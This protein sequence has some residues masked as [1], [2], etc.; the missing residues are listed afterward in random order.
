[1]FDFLKTRLCI[2]VLRTPQCF[3]FLC[4]FFS[5]DLEVK[6]L[7]CQHFIF[8]GN[9]E[10]YPALLL[11]LYCRSQRRTMLLFQNYSVLFLRKKKKKSPLLALF[12]SQDFYPKWP[13]DC[14][15]TQ[16]SSAPLVVRVTSLKRANVRDNNLREW[17]WCSPCN[18]HWEIS[19]SVLVLYI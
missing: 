12:V 2:F 4:L 8:Y 15:Y 17:A 16:Q 11:V 3:D 9:P 14:A 1:M 10:S 18:I 5:S 19:L 6:Y 7:Q 13:G